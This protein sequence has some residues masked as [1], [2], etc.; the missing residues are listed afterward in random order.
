MGTSS[1]GTGPGNNSPLLPNWAPNV[2]PYPDS[3]K[4]KKKDKDVNDKEKEKKDDTGKDDKKEEN[5]NKPILT[6]NWGSVKATLGKLA[7]GNKGSSVKSVGKA[8]INNL[9][10]VRNAVRGSRAGI[11]SGAVY[12][13]FLN[14][15]SE[16]GFT[17]TLTEYGLSDCIGK[18]TEEVFARIADRISPAGDTNEDAIAR[19]AL[20]ASLEVLY[21]KYIE[22]NGDI[23]ALNNEKEN[24]LKEA[25][26]EYISSYIF[27]KWLY[28]LGLAIENKQIDESKAMHLEGE[29]KEFIHGEVKVELKRKDITKI[30]FGT[31]E[32]KKIIENIFEQSYTTIES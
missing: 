24:D 7:N 9:G 22:G 3:D 23:T 17:Q 14:S 21:E 10:G 12:A 6:G 1:S 25:V 26:I 27:Y 5:L 2:D 13:N 8:Y 29:I 32:G 28:E 4:D 31:G 19:K 16:R 15:I 11:S 20:L 30:D 18:S